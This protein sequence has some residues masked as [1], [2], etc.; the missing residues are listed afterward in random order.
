M[1]V[2]ASVLGLVERILEVFD[3]LDFVVSPLRHWERWRDTA[4]PI[5]FFFAA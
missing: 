4:N 5:Q 3:L 2:I 1:A